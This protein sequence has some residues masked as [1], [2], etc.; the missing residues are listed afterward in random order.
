M[1]TKTRTTVRPSGDR[2][3]T[4]GRRQ[5]NRSAVERSR[6]PALYARGGL[7]QRRF[8]ERHHVQRS[9][10]MYWLRQDRLRGIT[11]ARRV[12]VELPGKLGAEAAPGGAR[13]LVNIRLVNGLKVRVGS[14][15]EALWVGLLLKELRAS[16]D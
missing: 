14:N 4:S 1:S 11:P 3:G 10:L 8:C 16:F 12:I 13:N 2:D 7:S 15:T 5:R 6:L 9:A